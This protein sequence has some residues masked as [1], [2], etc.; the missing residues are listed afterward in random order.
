MVG[1]ALL[2]K[3]DPDSHLSKN[4][5]ALEAPRRAV[6]V[7]NVGVEIQNRAMEGL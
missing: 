6:D 7:Y 4:S 1:Y 5:G 3:L 2:G